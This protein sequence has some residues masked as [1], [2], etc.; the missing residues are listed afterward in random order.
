MT[1]IDN[2]ILYT[3]KDIQELFQ[4]GRSKT[5]ELMRIKSFPKI[6]IGKQYYIPKTALE[7]WIESSV[8]KSI[9]IK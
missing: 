3:A 7:K 4:M 5:Y 1:I 6:K 2:R 9:I 8:Y